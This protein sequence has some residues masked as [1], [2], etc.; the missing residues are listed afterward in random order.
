MVN[1]VGIKFFAERKGGDV[2]IDFVFGM[3]GV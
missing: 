2:D 1:C 3:L